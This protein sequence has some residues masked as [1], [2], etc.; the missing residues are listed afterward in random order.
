MQNTTYALNDEART[1]LAAGDIT[2]LLALKRDQF[3]GFF[4]EGEG[5]DPAPAD[6]APAD[7]APADPADPADPAEDPADDSDPRVKRANAQAAAARVAKNE[8]Q[9]AL[10][11]AQDAQQAQLDAIAKALGLKSDDDTPD[12]GKLTAQVT[13]LTGENNNLRAALLVHELAGAHNANPVALLDSNKFSA[14]LQKLDASADDYRDK[15]TEAVKAAVTE[16]AAY[17]A[18]QGSGQGGSELNPEARERAKRARPTSLGAAI[19][20]AYKS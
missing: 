14:V 4:M 16:N 19:G 8:A 1:A 20:G 7:P 18:D 9:T 12:A 10:K 2:A 13:D 11:A 5:G 15:V 17:R 3:G 6:P